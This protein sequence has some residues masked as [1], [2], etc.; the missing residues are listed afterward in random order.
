VEEIKA[1][2]GSMKFTVLETD[3]EKIKK[4]PNGKVARSYAKMFI[5]KLRNVTIEDEK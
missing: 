2:S 3:L 4:H 1:I 5:E